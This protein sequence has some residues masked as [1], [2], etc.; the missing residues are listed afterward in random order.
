MKNEKKKLVHLGR[1]GSRTLSSFVLLGWL[2]ILEGWYLSWDFVTF[3]INDFGVVG[4][5]QGYLC[6]IEK[7]EYISVQWDM[8]LSD[9]K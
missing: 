7:L 2:N 6:L 9:K 3:L 8:T 5:K 1:H 4:L